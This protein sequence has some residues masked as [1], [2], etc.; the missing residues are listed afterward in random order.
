MTATYV[1]NSLCAQKN[2]ARDKQL[3]KNFSFSLIVCSLTNGE[4]LRIARRADIR[5]EYSVS[6]IVVDRPEYSVNKI[7]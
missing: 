1:Q 3:Q 6:T 4:Q 5:I 2:H 7:R